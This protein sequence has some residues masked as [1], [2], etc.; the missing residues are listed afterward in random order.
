MSKSEDGKKLTDHQVE[1]KLVAACNTE[2]GVPLSAG[3]SFSDTVSEWLP[4][5][6]EALKK[7]GLD[8]AAE[9][10]PV[11][12]GIAENWQPKGFLMR[13]LKKGMLQ[14]ILDLQTALDKEPGL[15]DLVFA[16]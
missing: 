8:L 4:V 16:K 6:R 9:S 1:S 13:M 5:I 2:Y 7:F 10:L 12:Q 14:A 11:L 3:N 15:G